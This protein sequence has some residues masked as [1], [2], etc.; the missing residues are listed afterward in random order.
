MK[1]PLGA[2]EQRVPLGDLPNYTEIAVNDCTNMSGSEEMAGNY[3][4]NPPTLLSMF[5]QRHL[6]LLSERATSCNLPIRAH[7]VMKSPIRNQKSPFL[8]TISLVFF[9]PKEPLDVLVSIH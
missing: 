7:H 8:V 6:N 5:A 1:I 2:A 4:H 9:I 3:L